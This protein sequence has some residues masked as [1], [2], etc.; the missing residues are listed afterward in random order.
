MV[1]ECP[2]GTH[3]SQNGG[4]IRKDYEE[5]YGQEC[6]YDLLF[7]QSNYEKVIHWGKFENCEFIRL[8]KTLLRCIKKYD[9]KYFRL[10]TFISRLFKIT[11]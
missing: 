7:E 5:D 9:V 1:G 8:N 6:F 11:V 10:L 4:D 2:S 3:Y